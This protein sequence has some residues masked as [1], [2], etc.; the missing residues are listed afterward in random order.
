MVQRL[1]AL[2]RCAL[3]AA[4]AISTVAWFSHGATTQRAPASGPTRS[5]PE[6]ATGR[7]EY[8]V[9]VAR[10]HMV[11]TANQIASEAGR[12]ILRDGG[13]AIDAAVAIQ[14]VLN[15][16]EPQS[17]GIGGGA[18]LLHFDAA[19]RTLKT[20]DGRET[21]PMAARPD[22]FLD[23]AGKPM[24][25]AA[26][27]ASGA[28]VGVPGALA[29][30]ELV[31]RRHGRLP[32]AQLFVPA[33][34][35]AR[36][37]FLVSPRLALLLEWIGSDAF[38]A[39]ARRYFFDAKGKAWSAGHRLRNPEFAVTL[40]RLAAEGSRAIHEGPIAESIVQAVAAGPAPAGELT[41]AD[42]AAYRP[43]ERD[44]ACV[45]YRGLKVCSMGP[46]SSGAHTIGQ[47][48]R[49]IE[50]FDL[51]EG[52]RAALNARAMH[53]IAEA[54][55]L[56]YADRNRY[57]VDPDFVRIPTG[58]LSDAYLDRRRKLIA[59]LSAAER[60]QPGTPDDNGAALPGEDYT[61]EASGTSHVSIIDRDGNAVSMTTTIEAAFGSRIW[62]A[63]FLL[64]NEL[65]DFSFRPTDAQGRPIANRIEAG[66]RPRSSM[67]PTIVFDRNGDVRAVLGSPGGSRIILYVVKSIVALV[68]WDMDAQAA[69]ALANFGSRGQGFELETTTAGGSA[70]MWRPWT[71]GTT[72]WQAL[73]LKPFGHRISFDQ[74]TSG[75]QIVVRRGPNHLEGGADPR[76]EGAALGD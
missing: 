40:E 76:R 61:V 67:A 66:K 13:N 68:D 20:Y 14:L 38:S 9:A 50:P 2:A 41:L 15:L 33:I 60:V 44:A 74:M 22:R 10:Q 23:A 54:E 34:T 45:P 47:T 27:V 51:G 43:R 63:G 73:R 59:P 37:G 3:P 70:P 7:H 4:L 12:K 64:N 11:S 25:F 35:L 31:H 48:L 58:L 39:P 21:A 53:L 55:N 5:A 18:F 49:L 17:S 8:A 75:T 72:I 36:D 28:A 57:L 42:L 29:M 24:R 69:A 52:P 71:W 26:A 56:A 62:A 30:L 16:V 65:T 6:A 1:F 46:P 19:T 32:W